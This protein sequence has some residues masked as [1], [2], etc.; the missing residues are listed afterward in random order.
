MRIALRSFLSRYQ[1]LIK[2]LK[3]TSI[4]SIGGIFAKGLSVISGV[5]YT[6]LILPEDMG[7][8]GYIMVI[9][10]VLSAFIILGGD[11]AYARYFFEAKSDKEKK[12][13]T[14]TWFL[15]L[16]LWSIVI[17][18]LPLCFID[19][20]ADWIF[21]STK[22]NI[23]IIA[24]LLLMPIKLMTVLFNQALR[25][26]FRIKA[27]VIC[28][29]VTAVFSI[30]FSLLGLIVFDFGVAS[31]YLGIIVAELIMIWP[32]IYLNRK[33][34]GLYFKLSL[35]KELLKFGVPF[36]PASLA[37]WV[38][39]SADRI[40]IEHFL[41]LEAVGIYTVALSMSSVLLVATDAFGEAWS[42]NA[43]K[44]YEEDQNKA[45]SLY[46]QMF[47]VILLI[48]GVVVLLGALIGYELVYLLFSKQYSAS[49]YPAMI[50]LAGIAFKMTIQITASGIGL[51]KKTHYIM[52][53]TML[54]A[55]L[56]IGFNYMMIPIYGVIGAAIATMLSHLFV[57]VIYGLISQRLFPINYPLKWMGIFLGG[58]LLSLYL[59]TIPVL[60]RTFIFA[61]AL[62]IGISVKLFYKRED[63][64]L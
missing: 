18:L 3:E 31:I 47:K 53:T 29:I 44:A 46:Q 24:G 49:F 52:M 7:A 15:F 35:L 6:H 25:N 43:V 8:Y 39:S 13:L 32:R 60:V 41:N 57:T 27:F 19:T 40:M 21:Q 55:V 56:N 33:L 63:E 54:I 61:L 64:V 34:L 45:K 23:L 5:F 14:S 20:I 37:V 36:V 42:P 17:I 22:Y 16:F 11:N 62:I 48:G 10:S 50:L 38:F 59:M 9:T 58:I 26:T 12:V 4:Y 51:K 1:S 30:V 28:N 2:V